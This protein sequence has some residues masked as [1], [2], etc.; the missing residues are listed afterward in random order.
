MQAI[1]HRPQTVE[2]KDSTRCAQGRPSGWQRSVAVAKRE[3]YEQLDSPWTS[4]S[5]IA[6]QLGVPRTTLQDWRRQ[7]Q[8]LL[9]HSGL[10]PQTVEFFESSAGLSFLH[11][12]L[13]AAHQ[14]FG[15]AAGGGI[16]NLCAFL[17]L[18]G[19]SHFAAASYGVQRAAAEEIEDLI[20]DDNAPNATEEFHDQVADL[21]A[22]QLGA[23]ATI[24][25]AGPIRFESRPAS[26]TEVD[27]SKSEE[28]GP[29]ETIQE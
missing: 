22:S 10:H 13:A 5:Q 29:S 11:Q 14:I 27:K 16:R 17:E 21:I 6:R 24:E 8:R 23:N 20:V 18:S 12:L 26:K 28:T 3:L 9:R 15:Q 4:F 25:D 1:E 7:K 19:L 2:E